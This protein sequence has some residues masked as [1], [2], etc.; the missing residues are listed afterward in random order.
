[1]SLLRILLSASLGTTLLSGLASGAEAQDI[2]A[3]SPAQHSEN[4]QAPVGTKPSDGSAAPTAQQAG[5]VAGAGYAERV[6]QG[7]RQIVLRD[8]EGALVTL[9]TAAQLEPAL[10]AAFCHLGD[11]QIGREN[12][13]EAK[14]AYEGCA[15][16]SALAKDDRYGT[17]AA[18][19][20]ARVAELSQA[21][22]AE[23]RDAYIRLSAATQDN[24]AKAMAQG[25]LGVLEA[26]TASEADYVGVRKRI[27]DREAKQNVKAK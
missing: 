2:W 18:V 27:A 8:F 21:P 12:W 17:L 3:A 9:R 20:S 24:T 1:M 15:R 10:P 26:L 13:L 19:G 14:A 7:L 5:A 23:R 4:I 16:F 25:R 22:L 11:A 6:L